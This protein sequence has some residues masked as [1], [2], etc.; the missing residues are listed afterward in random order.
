[1]FAALAP[2]L[3]RQAFNDARLSAGLPPIS[4]SVSLAL[5]L[6]GLDGPRVTPR[7]LLDALARLVGVGR[8]A[9]V[10]MREETRTVL[11]TGLAGAAA[12]GSASLLAA[13]GLT[14]LAKTGTAPMPRGGMEGLLVALVP[15]ERPIRG[16]VVVAPGA[17]GLDAAGM[18]ADLLLQPPPAPSVSARAPVVSAPPASRPV[19]SVRVG[20]LRAD[21]RVRV[22][23]LP[24]EDYVARVLAGEGQPRAGRAAQE[25]LAIAIR[26]FALANRNRHR[27]EGFDLCDSTHCQVLRPSTPATQRAAETTAGRLLVSEGAPAFVFYSAWCGGRSARPSEVWPG[28]ED[29]AVES[30]LDDDAC[31]EEP[32]WASEL[33]VRDLEQALR[34][35][36]L[37]GSRLRDL[38][39]VARSPSGRVARLRADGFSPNEIPGHELR[40]AIGRVAGWQHVKSTAFDLRR[41]GRGYRFAGRGFGHGVGLCVVG[42]GHRAAA[43][44]TAEDILRFYYP[45]LQIG[46]ADTTAVA[47]SRAEAAKEERVAP[48]SSSDVLLALPAADASERVH[49][50]NLVR[51]A[52]DEIAKRA[53][54]TPPASVRITVHPS[55]ESFGRAT[56]QPWWV[57]GATLGRSI[58][59]LPIRVL[60]QRGQL[61]RTIR[62][63]MAHV[64]IDPPLESRPLWVR[65]GAAFYFAAPDAPAV[66]ARRVS[67]PTDAELSRPLSAGSQ[68]D[69][70]ARADACFRNALAQGKSWREVK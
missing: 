22:E 60:R 7:A 45:G 14:A 19:V 33:N 10:R 12:Y 8:D 42:A 20:M 21:G 39:V 43:G 70:Y 25:A 58:D 11:R 69:A 38:R 16:I 41:T 18:A 15:A 4:A 9:P 26:T 32:A 66:A 61:E 30:P 23:T 51:A 1:F 37:R 47:L 57:S 56:G 63:E 13:R 62:H 28:A 46:R 50:V 44:A 2:R 31:T 36:G 53:G 49:V 5:A 3:P 54:V 34:S 6:V 48:A 52:R 24:L 67:C 65:E 64:L 35:A 27:R 40:M 59:L 55:A 68:R 17:A 29:Y